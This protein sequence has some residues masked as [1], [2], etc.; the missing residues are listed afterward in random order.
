MALAWKLYFPDCRRMAYS[1]NNA[2]QPSWGLALAELGKIKTPPSSQNRQHFPFWT[3]PHF[4]T[5][6]LVD[7]PQYHSLSNKE[8]V[9]KGQTETLKQSPYQV[10]NIA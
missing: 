9:E 6:I 8:A 1:E 7:F 10:L 4:G 5:L 2:T 3:F